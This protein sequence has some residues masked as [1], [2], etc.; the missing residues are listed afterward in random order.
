M[1]KDFKVRRAARGVAAA[2]GPASVDTMVREAIRLCW[3]LLP[4]TRN[5]PEDVALEIRRIVDR[6]LRDLSEDAK[7]FGLRDEPP[8]TGK[9]G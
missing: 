6:A 1:E 8:E 2:L 4:V 3:L 9:R 5:K 7:S